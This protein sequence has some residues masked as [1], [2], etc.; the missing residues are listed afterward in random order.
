LLES[1]KSVCG[2]TAGT[3]TGNHPALVQIFRGIFL[4]ALGM[5]FSREA[6]ERNAP[7]VGTSLLSPFLCMGMN[8]PICQSFGALPEHQGTWHTWVSQRS[9]WFKA[10]S[11]SGQISS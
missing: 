11:T 10:L 6:K 4:K 3:K 9:T 2:A 1:E 7:E 8:T 5:H